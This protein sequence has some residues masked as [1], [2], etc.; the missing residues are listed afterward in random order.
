MVRSFPWRLREPFIAGP[1]DTSGCATLLLC[2]DGWNAVHTG[3][4]RL[5]QASD[6]TVIDYARKEN[7][8]IITL[9]ADF[10]AI[11]A[12]ENACEPSVIR[13]RREGLKADKLAELIKQI[14]PRISSQLEAG[15]LV[16]VTEK[17]IRIRGIPLIES[18]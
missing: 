7:R 3:D 10:H 18:E 4:I 5:S 13:I 2:R 15:A 14:W 11:L 8:I 12:V 17:S 9:D 16:T 6:R 1:G